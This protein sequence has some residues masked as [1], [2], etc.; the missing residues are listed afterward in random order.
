MYH[1]ALDSSAQTTLATAQMPRQYVRGY[2]RQE[3]SRISGSGYTP[4]GK[5]LTIFQELEKGYTQ[6]KEQGARDWLNFFKG[7]LHKLPETGKPPLY[8]KMKS[9]AFIFNDKKK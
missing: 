2:D 6:D 1:Q 7:G 8:P 5:R 4:S 9:P 3:V